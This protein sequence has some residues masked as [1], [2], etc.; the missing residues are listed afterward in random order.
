MSGYTF[1]YTSELVASFLALRE[2]DHRFPHDASSHDETDIT[3]EKEHRP[4]LRGSGPTWWRWF[5]FPPHYDDRNSSNPD[6]LDGVARPSVLRVRNSSNVFLHNFGVTDSPNWAVQILNSQNVVVDGLVIHVNQSETCERSGT[7]NCFQAVN[8][9]GLDIANSRDVLVQNSE[10]FAHDDALMIGA[11]ERWGVGQDGQALSE[12]I[13]IQNSRLHSVQG[14]VTFDTCWNGANGVV[15]NVLLE[16]IVLGSDMLP[17]PRKPKNVDDPAV[18]N[19]VPVED[20]V[21]R[22]YPYDSAYSC[23]WNVGGQGIHFR[24]ERSSPPGRSGRGGR[25]GVVAQLL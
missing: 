19:G 25:S 8:T 17:P 2:E 3:F 16:N 23:P 4:L 13:V 24:S 11:A 22:Q 1:C 14:A 6:L 7:K 12:N 5:N 20:C 21:M 15:R 10:I 18:D 9:D